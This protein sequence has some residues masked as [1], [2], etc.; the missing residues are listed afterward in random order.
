VENGEMRCHCEFIR[1]ND[2][3]S[4]LAVPCDL[5]LA[6]TGVFPFPTKAPGDSRTPIV[7]SALILLHPLYRYPLIMLAS[8][9]SITQLV[10]S[11]DVFFLV[12]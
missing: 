10:P 12:F 9:P 3:L 4:S 11:P 8:H 6:A 1:A 5:E 7:R 2:A